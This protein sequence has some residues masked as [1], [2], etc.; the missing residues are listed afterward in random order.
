MGVMFHKE[1]EARIIDVEF[2]ARDG[3]SSLVADTCYV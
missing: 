1:L 2:L 3:I